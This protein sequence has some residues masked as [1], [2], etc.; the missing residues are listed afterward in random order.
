MKDYIIRA[1]DKKGSIRVFIAT[2]T[3]MVE[4]ARQIHKTAPTATAALG[5]VLT[6]ASIMGIMLKGD[7]DK[8]SLHIKGNGPIK[9]IL[10]VANSKGEVK[11][12][13]SNPN[14]DMP[15][16]EDGKL[17]VGM[18]VGRE[19]KIIVI[20]D[21]GLREP[22]IGRSSLVTGEIAEDLTHYFAYSEQQPSAVA[23]GVLVDR[24]LSVKS[25]G[26]FILQV[27]PDASDEV[28]TKLEHKLNNIE[29]ISSLIDR[30]YTPEDILAHIFGEFEM[31]ILEKKDIDFVCDCSRERL[32]EALVSVGKEELERIIKE[33]GKAELVCHFCNT[34]YHF[35]K[36]DLERLLKEA[37][38]SEGED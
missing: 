7:K 34:K 9:S 20:K 17:N 29:P 23:L 22:Y 38:K 10:A 37:E 16:R 28:I 2:T 33:D 4:K 14:V 12:Y 35:D 8:V 26:G 19:G 1:I 15:L 31:E 3:N 25:S 18:A 5:R 24:D 30:G 11:G 36:R 6:A 13:I 21:L 32:E 27:L